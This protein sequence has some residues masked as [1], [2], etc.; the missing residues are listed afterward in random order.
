MYLCIIIRNLQLKTDGTLQER[1]NQLRRKIVAGRNPNCN[2]LRIFSL[3]VHEGEFEADA[4]IVDPAI[5]TSRG[6]KDL[7]QLVQI[8]NLKDSLTI[9]QRELDLVIKDEGAQDKAHSPSS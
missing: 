9:L 8:Q 4:I 5:K 7:A 2:R 1:L 3:G 6:R